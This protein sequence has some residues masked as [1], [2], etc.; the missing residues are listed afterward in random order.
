MA[1]ALQEIMNSLVKS[2][3]NHPKIALNA[4][5]I[6]LYDDEREQIVLEYICCLEI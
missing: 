1:V 2:K 3:E 4:L 5:F 6:I